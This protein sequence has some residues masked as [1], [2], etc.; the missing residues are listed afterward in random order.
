MAGYSVVAQRRASLL[1]EN[2]V[3]IQ[4]LPPGPPGWPVTAS[5]R[6]EEQDMRTRRR[7]TAKADASYSVIE[8]HSKD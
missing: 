8:I 4:G 2:A 1:G 7:V 3:D 5:R 6:T